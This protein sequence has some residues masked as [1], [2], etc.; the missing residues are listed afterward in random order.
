MANG[1]ITTARGMSLN[2]DE[3]IQQAQ[4]PAGMVDEASTRDTGNFKTAV[5]NAPRVRG[6][7]P[8]AGEAT[9]HAV[10]GVSESDTTDTPAKKKAVSKKGQTKT[11]AEMTQVTVKQSDAAKVATAAQQAENQ[12]VMDEDET[13]GDIIS[14]MDQK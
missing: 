9:R 5:L 10:D 2:I 7:V 13:L 12:P 8:S 4:R 14:G 11:L 3:I 6:F 1:S